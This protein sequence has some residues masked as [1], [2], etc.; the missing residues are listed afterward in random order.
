MDLVDEQ[1]D[2]DHLLYISYPAPGKAMGV[3]CNLFL[4]ISVLILSPLLFPFSLLFLISPVIFCSASFF[5]FF[6]SW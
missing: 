4:L 2:G 3:S 5:F 6:N 1:P